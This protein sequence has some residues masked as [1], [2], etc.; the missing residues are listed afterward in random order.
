MANFT[1]AGLWR[2]LTALPLLRARQLRIVV[3]QSPDWRNTPYQD[4]IEDSRAFC[5]MIAKPVA[6]PENF[7]SDVIAVWDRMFAMPF[8][9]VRAAMKDIAQENL[10][11]VKLAAITPI[12]SLHAGD[13]AAE[14]LYLFIDDD[15]WLHP[16]IVA[17]LRP[18]LK[19]ENDGY[20]FG[21]VLCVSNIQLRRIEDG[22]YTNNYAVSRRFMQAQSGNVDRVIQHWAANEAFH[23]P[24]F[25]LTQVPLYVSATNKHPASTMKLK[26]GLEEHELSANTLRR[27]IEKFVDESADA[28]APP[29]AEWVVPYTRK[30]RKVFATLVRR[31]PII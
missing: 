25:R 17:E 22:C 30:V 11:A 24:E 2:R 7:I 9:H 5:R 6:I 23:R 19:D 1:G 4:L 29:E 28:I 15:D 12:A 31:V 10:S 13:M 14:P 3:R 27:L 26:D 21:N 16:N 8:F 18:F 20:I